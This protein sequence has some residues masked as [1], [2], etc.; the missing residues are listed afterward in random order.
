MNFDMA[1]NASPHSFFKKLLL[2]AFSSYTCK[3][4]SQKIHLNQ[5]QISAKLRLWISKQFKEPEASYTNTYC[6][7]LDN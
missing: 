7:G 1:L 6:V 5:M 3:L 2:L 4:L